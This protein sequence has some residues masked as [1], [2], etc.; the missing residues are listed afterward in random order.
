MFFVDRPLMHACYIHSILSAPLVLKPV[1]TLRQIPCPS[2][3]FGEVYFLSFL[4]GTY[5]CNGGCLVR[6][7]T[8]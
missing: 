4:D 3:H 2:T 1:F 7:M 8:L 6:L 5:Y